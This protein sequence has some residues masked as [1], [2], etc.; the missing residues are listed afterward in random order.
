MYGTHQPLSLGQIPSGIPAEVG[1]VAT[2]ST[3][4]PA[5]YYSQ[6]QQYAANSRCP[7]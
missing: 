6:P 4:P 2:G 5:T 1:P 7:A 3:Q